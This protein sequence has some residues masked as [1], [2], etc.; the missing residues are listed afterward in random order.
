M[1]F[2]LS[3]LESLANI[4]Q[5][6]IIGYQLLSDSHSG[7]VFL[8]D[9]ESHKQVVCKFDSNYDYEQER[10]SAVSKLLES[11]NYSLSFLSEKSLL[12]IPKT[13]VCSKNYLA[14]D[15][16][17]DYK[18]E[19]RSKLAAYDI[20]ALH[21]QTHS[22]FGFSKNNFIGGII[23]RNEFNSSWSNFYSEQRL[24]PVAELLLK[25]E[26]IGPVF[27]ERLQSFCSSIGQY[28]PSNP[29]I[30]LLHG[31][32]WNG[33]ILSAQS[34]KLYYI[35]PAPYYGHNEIEIAFL[36]MFQTFDQEFYSIY[37]SFHKLDNDFYSLRCPIYQIY[38][39]LI[40]ALL[41]EDSSYLYSVN[42][43]LKQLSF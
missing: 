4:V 10:E 32:L 33:N 15:Y 19:S 39:N 23:Q 12:E 27:F 31:D 28:I 41:Y 7:G 6:N 21:S 34:K 16:I 36:L 24:L 1:E 37:N 14:M 8:I 22:S 38:P 40:H 26:I 9:F 42:K 43:I 11:E 13:I 20:S 35:D 30:S 3:K 25:K 17:K 18:L 29:K 5:S 2:D